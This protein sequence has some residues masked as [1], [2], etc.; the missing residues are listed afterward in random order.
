[1]EPHGDDKWDGESVSS[2]RTRLPGHRYIPP[3]VVEF[4][5]GLVAVHI[6]HLAIHQNQVIGKF[7]S[8]SKPLAVAGDIG[9]KN[10]SV[11]S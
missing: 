4:P 3:L 2:Q 9:A 6:R 5:S 11:R 1:M 7:E 10:P 8:A